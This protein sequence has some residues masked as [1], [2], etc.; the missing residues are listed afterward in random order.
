MEAGED[1]VSRIGGLY[2]Q[3]KPITEELVKELVSVF[4]FGD[5]DRLRNAV[6]SVAFRKIEELSSVMKC[7]D[8]NFEEWTAA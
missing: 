6:G 7:I 2:G 3:L 5:R 8:A 4:D 1:F